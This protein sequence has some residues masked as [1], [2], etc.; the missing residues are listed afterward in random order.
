M[1]EFFCE[2]AVQHDGFPLCE[3]SDYRI[4]ED[5]ELQSYKDFIKN[6]PTVDHPGAFGQH[7]NADIASQ[8]DD[9]NELITTL[10]SIQSGS[11]QT[12]DVQGDSQL[13][14]QC[15]DLLAQLP[16]LFDYQAI[17]QALEGRSDPEPMKIVL[18]QE[19][20]RYNV[21]LQTMTRT[22]QSA[23]NM[24]WDAQSPDTRLL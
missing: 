11:T 1:S 23:N 18:L 4:P 8:I 7:P 15:T 17:K 22:L 9:A 6:L 24:Q 20:I 21:Q 16:E 5:G 14:K 19:V 13:A 10:G 12:A 2:A 3:L